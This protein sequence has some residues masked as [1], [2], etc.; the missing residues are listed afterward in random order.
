[1]GFVGLGKIGR[2]FYDCNGRDTGIGCIGPIEGELETGAL[3]GGG[4]VAGVE[5]EVA[6]G[7]NGGPVEVGGGEGRG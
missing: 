7:R 6:R 3:V 2:Q 4:C 1:M 5:S